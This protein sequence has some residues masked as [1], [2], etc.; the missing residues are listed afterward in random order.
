MVN[1]PPRV[2]IL[3]GTRAEYGLLKPLFA[4]FAASAQVK[5]QVLVTG[6]HLSPEFG[7]TWREI[8]ADGYSI[9]ERVEIV[10]SSD[11]RVGVCKSMG[12][13]LAGFGE[14]LARLAPQLLV[15]LGDRYEVLC[16]AAAANVLNIPVA[17][18]HGG[19]VTEGAIDDAFRHAVSKLSHLHFTSTETYRARVVQMGEAPESVF[20]VGAIGLDAL[21]QI[22]LLD[23]PALA[24]SIGFDLGAQHLLLTYHPET[25]GGGDAGAE[26]QLLLDTVLASGSE[27][28]LVT[29]ANAD[30]GGRAINQVLA[31]VQ[32]AHPGRI[33]VA[34]SLGQLRYL[35]AMRLA[36]AV[37]GNSSSGIIEAP[38]LGV[39][40]VNVG[41][42]QHGRIRAM[43]VIDAALEPAALRGALDR[44]RD[45]AFRATV[46]QAP[47]PYGDGRTAPRVA[48]H[49]EQALQGKDLFRKAFRDLAPTP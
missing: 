9:D 24:R 32:A 8:V 5:L 15:V 18:L 44:C 33:F 2:C 45:P 42:R 31:Q 3:T 19:E 47:N 1:P 29:G 20:N 16:A 34:A 13:A 17:H 27:Q 25:V 40:T 36:T 12:L 4:L 30:A 10:L 35:S 49:I 43:S 14:A 28:L 46:A 48:R 7:S 26:M 23:R 41:R 11:S 38:S 22:E 21:R 37:V 6:T 39:P